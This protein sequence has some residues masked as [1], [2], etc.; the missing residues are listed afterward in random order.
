MCQ[1]GR[2]CCS[3]LFYYIFLIM[4]MHDPTVEVTYK[5]CVSHNRSISLS[6]HAFANAVALRPLYHDLPGK[7]RVRDLYG[8]CI[9]DQTGL[10][11]R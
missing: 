10:Y 1:G 8:T 9:Q 4:C 6:G 2:K 3:Y 7:L 5:R 11:T